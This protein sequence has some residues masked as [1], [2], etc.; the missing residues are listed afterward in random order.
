MGIFWWRIIFFDLCFNSSKLIQTSK[1]FNGAFN[2]LIEE[3]KNSAIAFIWWSFFISFLK[4]ISSCFFFR[5]SNKLNNRK[6]VSEPLSPTDVWFFSLWSFIFHLS[7]FARNV[8][9]AC[10][11]SGWRITSKECFL[12]P[13]TSYMLC[14]YPSC[15]TL[16]LSYLSSKLFAFN[17]SKIFFTLFIPHLP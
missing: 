6:S 9:K 5:A 3:L 4:Q 17:S 11:C 14:F 1:I 8:A 2:F 12:H 16:C 13:L 7:P 15:L 10:W